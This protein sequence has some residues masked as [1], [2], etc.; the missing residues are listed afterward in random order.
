MPLPQICRHSNSIS[1]VDGT[2]KA[3]LT[4]PESKRGAV[5]EHRAIETLLFLPEKA[6]VL[7]ALALDATVYFW[8]LIDQELVYTSAPPP[9]PPSFRPPPSNAIVHSSSFFSNACCVCR[10]RLIS[11]ADEGYAFETRNVS[12]GPRTQPSSPLPPHHEAPDEPSGE[13]VP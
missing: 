11:L 1:Q 9:P 3:T 8:R 6:R 7:A 4:V 13:R 5:T 10:A 2:P 12:R